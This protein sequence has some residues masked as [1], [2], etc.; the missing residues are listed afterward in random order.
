MNKLTIPTILVATVM[1]AGI[2]AFMPVEQA[3]TVHTTLGQL[4]VGSNTDVDTSVAAGLVVVATSTTIKQGTVCLTYTD[5]V[6]GVDTPDLLV[7]YDATDTDT[8]IANVDIRGDNCIDFAGFGLNLDAV[9]TDA[10]DDLDFTFGFQ[11]VTP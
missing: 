10:A 4:N 5:N 3:S 9:T 7:S 2:F 8:G 11:E 6:G 1:V